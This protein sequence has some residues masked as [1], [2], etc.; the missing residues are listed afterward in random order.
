MIDPQNSEIL[1]LVRCPVTRSPLKVADE[2]TLA[3]L[4]EQIAQ[5]AL[6]NRQGQSV[7]EPLE[8]ALINAD[9]SLAMPIRE[10]ILG[11][12]AD[13]AIPLDQIGDQGNE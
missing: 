6:F 9:G 5:Q 3:I 10:G 8:G 1:R 4:N 2:K 11:M 13:D 7:T 12:I